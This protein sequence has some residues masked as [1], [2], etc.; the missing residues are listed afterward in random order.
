M[1][2]VGSNAT[3]TIW[4]CRARACMKWSERLA[5][6]F[7]MERSSHQPVASMKPTGSSSAAISVVR[8]PLRRKA[9]AA[10]K[11]ESSRAA[12]NPPP[13]E[14]RAIGDAVWATNDAC[15][16][17]SQTRPAISTHERVATGHS[18]SRRGLRN[19]ASVMSTSITASNQAG[20]CKI[21]IKETASPDTKRLGATL[22][23]GKPKRAQTSPDASTASTGFHRAA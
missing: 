23:N 21:D 6:S 16:P 18:N 13:S 4:I 17:A 8:V 7:M 1:H 14:V 10:I 2:S 22:K 15:A 11:P 20:P 19:A 3:S 5:Y 9:S 12:Q